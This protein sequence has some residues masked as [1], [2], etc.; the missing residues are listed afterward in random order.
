VTP[1]LDNSHLNP[2]IVGLAEN[3]VRLLGLGW[4]RGH[5]K[6]F[7]KFDRLPLG[8]GL[9]VSASGSFRFPN[10]TRKDDCIVDKR[11]ALATDQVH[12]REMGKKMGGRQDG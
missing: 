1:S 6:R 12:W 10:A 2:I 3:V 8:L 11:I 9:G 5:A 7:A 4:C